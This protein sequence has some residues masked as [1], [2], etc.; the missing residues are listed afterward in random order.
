MPDPRPHT[1]REPAVITNLAHV[2][3]VV[4]DLQ[5]AIDFYCGKLGLQQAFEFRNEKG[6]LFGV[7]IK[8]GPRSFIEIFEKSG[9][10]PA[11][12]CSYSHLCLEVD[13]IEKTVKALRDGGLEVSDPELGCDQ[14]WQAWLAD[15]EG[16][17]I[18]LHAY[19]PASWQAPWL[20]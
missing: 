8:A 6:E 10:K 9:S 20:E 1:E 14:S 4:N 7:Y 17:R 13:D 11:G 15:P 16:N 18:E 2:C 5:K 12:E 19:T 3:F